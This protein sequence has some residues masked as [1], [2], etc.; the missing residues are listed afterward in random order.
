MCGCK[1]FKGSTRNELI[2]VRTSSDTSFRSVDLSALFFSSKLKLL[3]GNKLG[4]YHDVFCLCKEM[5]P[6]FIVLFHL[7]LGFESG[8]GQ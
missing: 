4:L 5:V 6:F 8:Q 1:Y 2:S 7:T 3:V